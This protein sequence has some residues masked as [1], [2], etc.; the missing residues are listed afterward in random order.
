M[1]IHLAKQQGETA[2]IAVAENSG[3]DFQWLAYEFCKTFARK[4]LSKGIPRVSSEEMTL[5]C[6]EAGIRP[7]DL[8]AFGAVYKRMVREGILT[9]KI[10]VQRRFGHGTSGGSLYRVAM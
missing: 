5:A 1:N 6:L 3:A 10:I 7:H 2:M 4:W 9:D 8:R